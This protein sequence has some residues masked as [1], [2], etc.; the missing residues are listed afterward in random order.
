[1]ATGQLLDTNVIIDFS[2]NK[3]SG[4]SNQYIAEILD[5]NPQIS[6]ITKIELLGFNYVSQQTK[7]FVDH[8]S[9]IGLD[10]DIVNQTIELRKRYRVKIPD[11]IIAATA[12]IFDLTV[13]TNNVN[14]FKNI[15]DLKLLNPY[16]VF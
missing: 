14:D 10:E 11:A 5:G 9:I 6:V 12:L 13:V 7:F 2:A 1:M 15:A 3:F 16:S 4:K 8:A